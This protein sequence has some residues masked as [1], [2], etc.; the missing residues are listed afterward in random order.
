[1]T[2]FRLAKLAILCLG[3]PTMSLAQSAEDPSAGLLMELNNLQQVDGNCR[4]SF[5]VQNQ[6]GAEIEAAS[7]EAVVFDAQGNVV[8][9]TLYKFRDIPAG[10]LRVRQF[11][12]ADMSC[13]DVG[14]ILINGSNT[15]T[16]EGA[17]SDLCDA[18]LT[19]NNRTDVEFLR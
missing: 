11:S 18:A 16:V 13:G 5:L 3:I 2:S 9:L 15:C 8:S 17:E 7:Y 19:L 4:L 12:I 6:T 14:R 10:R 1:M